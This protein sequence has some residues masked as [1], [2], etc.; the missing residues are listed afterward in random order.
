MSHPFKV[1]LDK[2]KDKENPE[3]WVYCHKFYLE[4]FRNDEMFLNYCEESGTFW[5]LFQ[6][7]KIGVRLIPGITQQMLFLIKKEDIEFDNLISR[8][9]I[10]P[11]EL[12]LQTHF[13]YCDNYSN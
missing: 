9:I 4:I 3:Y 12:L 8:N 13:D 10:I 6:G 2:S 7:A 11:R 5:F 1:I